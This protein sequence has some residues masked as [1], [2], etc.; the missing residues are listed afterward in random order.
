MGAKTWSCYN[1]NRVITNSVIKGL[2]C[3]SHDVVIIVGPRYPC[4][5]PAQRQVLEAQTEDCRL[6]LLDSLGGKIRSKI[7]LTPITTDWRAVNDVI[8]YMHTGKIIT[9][10][11]NSA[12]VL[13][14]SSILL[15]NQVPELCIEFMKHTL[16]CNTCIKY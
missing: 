13:K 10:A 7:D 14:I 16:D 15:V 9:G 3:T 2:K 4:C 11:L 1:Q 5:L 8:D 12:L 6:C